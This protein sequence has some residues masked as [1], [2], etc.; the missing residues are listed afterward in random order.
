MPSFTWDLKN[1]MA[2]LMKPTDMT[3][4]SH[5]FVHIVWLLSQLRW[6]H[7]CNSIADPY[8]STHKIKLVEKVCLFLPVVFN[9]L[10]I[11][12]TSEDKHLSL[13]EK[14]LLKWD[15][16]RDTCWVWHYYKNK[17]NLFVANSISTVVVQNKSIQRHY[18]FN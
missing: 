11:F 3:K 14:L 12:V 8:I 6:L 7:Y 1:L 10:I 17:C 9:K 2:L 16:L 15:L 18:E 13:V 4:I 5:I